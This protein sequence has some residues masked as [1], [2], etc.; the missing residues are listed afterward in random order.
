MRSGRFSTSAPLISLPGAPAP[1]PGSQLPTMQQVGG[2]ALAVPRQSPAAQGIASS[3]ALPPGQQR[4]ASQLRNPYGNLPSRGSVGEQYA[5][6]AAISSASL[7]AFHAAQSRLPPPLCPALVLDDCVTRLDFPV[8]KIDESRRATSG[9]GVEF[10]IDGPLRKA[11]FRA[12]ICEAP[13]GRALMVSIPSQGPEPW[14][15]VRPLQEH[16]RPL[17]ENLAPEALQLQQNLR[18][19]KLEIGYPDGTIY[20]IVVSQGDGSNNFVIHRTFVAIKIRWE[21]NSKQLKAEASNNRPVA[22]MS[23]KAE[24]SASERFELKVEPGFDPLLILACVLAV[25]ALV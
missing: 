21:R 16:N 7:P 17:L 22:E 1:L 9:Q 23:P 25:L 20:G 11:L 5:S 6:T 2:S 8:S 4:A 3:M 19:N 24:G 12:L 14:A 13:G 15:V 10:D 18:L